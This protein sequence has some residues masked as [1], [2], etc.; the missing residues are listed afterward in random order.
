[1]ARLIGLASLFAVTSAAGPCCNECKPPLVKYYSVDRAHGFCGNACMDPKKFSIYKKFEANLTLVD[2]DHP[3][4]AGQ[5][6][7]DG[8]FYTDYDSTVTHGDPFGV[9][10][11]TLDLYAPTGMPDH[12]CCS[13]PIVIPVVG[14]VNCKGKPQTMTIRGTGPYCCPASSTEEKPCSKVALPETCNT[15][16]R[17]ICCKNGGGDACVT[18]CGCEKGS[19]PPALAFPK[20]CDNECR[21]TC[22]KNG[23]GDAC[24][25]ACGCE[26]G[27][28]PPPLAFPKTCDTECRSI[29]CKNGGGD[30]CVTAC[31]CEKGSC[32]PPLALPKTCDTECRSTCCKNG[33]GDACVT[34][35]GCEKGSCPP[36]VASL[37][38]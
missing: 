38:V 13:T 33:G 2:A 5:Y 7:P 23:G 17:S 28:C 22:C 24:V 18:A 20:T 8:K 10:A 6:T 27:S 32:P 12:S 1:M 35:C 15:E 4:C 26:K 14:P 30:A 9:L 21:S 36:D 37:I 19:C 11:V 3:D 16:C 31:G 25:T 29:C 34:A